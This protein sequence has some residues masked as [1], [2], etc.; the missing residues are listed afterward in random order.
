MFSLKITR[1]GDLGTSDD[2]FAAAFG[3]SG[4]GGAVEQD[5]LGFGDLSIGQAPPPQQAPGGNDNW[6]TF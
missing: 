5:L 2:P 6:V 4:G 1:S 3:P